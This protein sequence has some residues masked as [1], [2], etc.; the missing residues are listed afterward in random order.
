MGIFKSRTGKN[1][2]DIWNQHPKIC[3][4]AKIVQNKKKKTIF[5]QKMP[6]LGILACKFGKVLS[7]FQQPRILQNE[8][9]RAKLKIFNCG[10]RNV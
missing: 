2:H 6:Y 10:T 1:N 3:I 8:K 4:N 7:Y 9:F 5:G